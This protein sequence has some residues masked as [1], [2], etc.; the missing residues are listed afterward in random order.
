MDTGRAPVS[1]PRDSEKASD[2]CKL[3]IGF[4]GN[5]VKN[6]DYCMSEIFLFI[7]IHLSV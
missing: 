7:I 2:I 4:V 5:N 3:R 6:L 1:M